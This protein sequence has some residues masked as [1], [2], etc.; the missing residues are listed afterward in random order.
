[1]QLS[2]TLAW[3]VDAAAETSGAD[4]LLAELGTRLTTDGLALAGGALTMAVP[5][6]L[7]ARRTWLWRAESGEVIEAFGFVPGELAAVGAAGRQD[8]AGR[9]WLAGLAAGVIHEDTIGSKADGPTLGWIGPRPFTSDEA[10]ELRQTARFA[11]A[12]LAALAARA[13]LTAALDAYL[14][15][16]SAAK[17]LAGPLR[18][19]LGETIQAALLFADLRGFTALSESNP[20]RR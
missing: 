3:L 5:H 19:N 12:S 17:V 4:R 2:S 18:R 16:R 11:A 9:R 8:D 6:P 20:L 15:R 1:M 10:D 13:T 14:G 7:I